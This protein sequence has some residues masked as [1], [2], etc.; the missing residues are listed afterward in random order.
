MDDATNASDIP[1]LIA[2]LAN[3]NAQTRI[4]A[5]LGL[6]KHGK[7]A[8]PALVVTLRNHDHMDVRW[9]AAYVLGL[10]AEPTTVPDLIEALNDH[11]YVAQSAYKALKVIATPEAVEALQQWE[12]S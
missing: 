2:E 3:D 6:I 7:V 9:Y 11:A 4:N 8:C 10:I 1:K 5:I 12:R